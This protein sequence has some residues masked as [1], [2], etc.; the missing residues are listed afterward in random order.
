MRGTSLKI[1]GLGVLAALAAAPSAHA[2]LAGGTNFDALNGPDLVSVEVTQNPEASNRTELTRFCFDRRLQATDVDQNGFYLAGYDVNDLVRSIRADVDQEG[3]DGNN[4]RCVVVEFEDGI[5]TQRFTV[6]GVDAN[7]VYA[8]TGGLQGNLADATGLS[9]TLE[10][11]NTAGANLRKAVVDVTRNDIVYYF[12]EPLGLDIDGTDFG[13]YDDEGNRYN[14]ADAQFNTSRTEVRVHFNLD[15]NSPGDTVADAERAFVDDSAVQDQGDDP[16]DG[17]N[18][19]F[20]SVPASFPNGDITDNQVSSRPDLISARYVGDDTVHFVFDPDCILDSSSID[21][22]DFQIRNRTGDGSDIITG[23][24]DSAIVLQVG[25][26]AGNTVAI[27]FNAPGAIDGYYVQAAVDQGGVRCNG[28]GFGDASNTLGNVPLQGGA[29]PLATFSGFTNAPD[30]VTAVFTQS[31]ARLVIN[32][33]ETVTD[34]DIDRFRLLGEN[35]NLLSPSTPEDLVVIDGTRVVFQL[36]NG[37]QNGIKGVQLL[38][39]AVEGEVEDD[40]LTQIVVV[41]TEKF[42]GGNQDAGG[43]NNGGDDPGGVNPPNG[44]AQPGPKPAAAAAP[45]P[46]AAQ[47]VAA[48]GG[49]APTARVS[50]ARSGKS[51]KARVLYAKYRKG[52]LTMKISGKAKKAKIKITLRNKKGKTIKTL[53]RTVRTNRQV[54]LKNLTTSTAVKSVKV[55]VL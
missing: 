49:S 7:V 33:D 39:D 25:P 22:S 45:A 4:Q 28:Q 1:T 15:P 34:V 35:G 9:N 12:D 26:N 16:G 41:R 51:A 18:N 48:A 10:D 36:Q 52:A 27:E 17:N 44:A 31:T 2:A 40:S 5:D 24:Q 32:F 6:G 14:G 37:Q 46:A 19:E 50:P 55:R 43:P 38:E 42:P 29:G 30:A 11:G 21:A 13:Y 3:G 54:T 8:Q 23:D 20:E 47:Q 53:T